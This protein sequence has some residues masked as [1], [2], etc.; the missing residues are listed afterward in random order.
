MRHYGDISKTDGAEIETAEIWKPVP[1]YEKEYM[2]SNK[3]R[4]K[5]LARLII[6][7]NGRPQ[8]IKERIL[9]APPDEWGYPQVRLLGR[10]FKV[11]RLMAMVFLG[12]RPDGFVVRH[13]DGNPKNNTLDNLEYG[14]ASQNVM[15]CYSYRGYLSKTQKLMPSDAIEIKQRLSNGERGVDLAREFGVSQQNVCDIKN[16]RT[17][18]WTE[19]LL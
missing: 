3:G 16:Y 2:V 11:H 4:V 9:K 12:E 13:K 7:N 17:F 18:A 8:T 19:G 10:T 5:S 15:D 14:T 6:R 1:G